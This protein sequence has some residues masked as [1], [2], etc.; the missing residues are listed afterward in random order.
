[1]HSST[2]GGDPHAASVP[3]DCAIGLTLFYF[4][5]FSALSFGSSGVQPV[6]VCSSMGTS[7]HSLRFSA[8]AP[9]RD[10]LA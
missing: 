4:N 5:Q 7:R 10:L 1:V 3:S 8:S 9:M 2:F 6:N